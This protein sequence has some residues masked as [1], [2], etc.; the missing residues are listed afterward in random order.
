[1]NQSFEAAST[2]AVQP[3]GHNK[4]G[5]GNNNSL[6]LPP[7]ESHWSQSPSFSGLKTVMK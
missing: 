6:S 7:P 1:M 3:R 2:A 5:G 4:G